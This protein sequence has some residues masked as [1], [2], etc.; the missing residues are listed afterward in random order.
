[1][2]ATNDGR[3]L[4]AAFIGGIS[5]FDAAKKKVLYTY[6]DDHLDIQQLSCTTIN[7]EM[8]IISAVDDLGKFIKLQKF[9]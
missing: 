7:A 5:M 3:Y 9:N 2:A 6:E 4:F 8:Y 1:M